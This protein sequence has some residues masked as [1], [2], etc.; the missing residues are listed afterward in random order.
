MSKTYTKRLGM[1][2]RKEGLTHEQFTEHWFT[3]HAELCKRLPG[4]RYYA[5][6]LVERDRFPDFGYDGFSELWFDSEADL[7]AAFA[8]PEGEVLL[9]DLDNFVERIDPLISV[10]H[11]ML[12]P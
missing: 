7:E 10:E 3:T 1:L 12:W 6:N 9:A 8:S 11:R 2:C 5:V 4:L